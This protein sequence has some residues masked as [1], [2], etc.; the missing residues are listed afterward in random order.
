[1]KIQVLNV[2]EH[3]VDLDL[4]ILYVFRLHLKRSSHI[5]Y[6]RNHFYSYCGLIRLS[7][8]KTL[9]ALGRDDGSSCQ[10]SSIN[11]VTSVCWRNC[12]D[13]I[14]RNTRAPFIGHFIFSIISEIKPRCG[15]LSFC[16]TYVYLYSQLPSVRKHW[17][18]QLLQR[19]LPTN[20]HWKQRN[21]NNN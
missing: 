16:S 3:T 10:Q 18:K 14:G 9:V 11:D 6:V 20:I 8:F 4:N 17:K 21:Q 19:L 1:M 2:V 7:A 5:F 13:N 12:N 15:V